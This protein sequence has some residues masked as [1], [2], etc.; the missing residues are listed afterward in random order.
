[1]QT[2]PQAMSTQ[3]SGPGGSHIANVI[4]ASYG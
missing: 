2:K 3:M 4:R 1:M